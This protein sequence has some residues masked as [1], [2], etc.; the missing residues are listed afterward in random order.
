V[1]SNTRI[2]P[3]PHADGS[4]ADPADAF[5]ASWEPGGVYRWPNAGSKPPGQFNCL[6]GWPPCLANRTHREWVVGAAVLTT[7]F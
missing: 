4:I 6:S 3:A 5:A 2:A 7:P 1:L